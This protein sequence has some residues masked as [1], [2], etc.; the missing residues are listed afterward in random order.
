MARRTYTFMKYRY[1]DIYFVTV[2]PIK[3]M[4]NIRDYLIANTERCVT[5]HFFAGYDPRQ[6]YV[7]IFSKGKKIHE[8][9]LPSYIGR[10]HV[11]KLLSNYVLFVYIL[12]F[13]VRPG[14]SVLVANP[15]FCIGNRLFSWLKRLRFVFWIG[16]YYPNVQGFMKLYN[17]LVLRY[18]KTL[19][20]VLYESPPIASIYKPLAPAGLYRMLVT[21]GMRAQSFA[22]RVRKDS[23]VVLGFIGVIRE[24]QGLDLIFRHLKGAGNVRLEVIGDGYFL[25]HYKAL[26]VKLGVSHKVKFLGFVE[27][28]NAVI[29]GWDI[30]MALYENKADNVSKYCEPTKI[31][32][33]L[34]CGLPVITTR[35]TYFYTELEKYG[36]GVAVDETSKSI[37]NAVHTIMR[38]RASF[39]GGVRKIVR[40]YRYTPWY[41]K[42]FSFLEKA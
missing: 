38:Q 34:E 12:F 30:G 39:I 4:G 18:N 37:Q 36:A 27:D 21:L 41:Q 10:N 2:D 16:D 35:T 3:N 11:L 25:P 9:R 19:P 32:D 15:V 31:K 1:K 13:Y 5:F 23:T 6:S 7:S 22:A 29:S 40:A 14:A 28:K 26:A 8:A 42:H 33:Y 17:A 20:Y 24:Q